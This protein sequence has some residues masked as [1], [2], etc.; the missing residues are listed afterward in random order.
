MYVIIFVALAMIGVAFFVGR[1]SKKEPNKF[2]R[3]LNAMGIR[4]RGKDLQEARALSEKTQNAIISILQI[5]SH[6]I[7]SSYAL[8]TEEDY[9][10][11]DSFMEMFSDGNSKRDLYH[12]AKKIATAV[13]ENYDKF[14]YC[15]RLILSVDKTFVLDNMISV[16]RACKNYSMEAFA[17]A[18]CDQKQ[19]GLKID[20]LS[21]LKFVSDGRDFAAFVNL[22]LMAKRAELD[23]DEAHLMNDIDD[24][25]LK[26]IIYSII[27]A[28][29][30]GIYLTDEESLNINKANVLEYSDSFKITMALLVDLYKLGRDVN[31]FTNVMIRAHNSGVMINIS[32]AEL[33]SMTDDEFDNL[34]TNIIRASDQGIS[35]DQKDLIRQNINGTDITNL[36]SALIKSNQCKLEFTPDD[37]MNYFVNTRSNVVNFVNAVDYSKKNKLG[38]SVDYLIEISKPE[39]NLF[40]FVQAVKIAKDLEAEE[41]NFGITVESVKEHFKKFNKAKEAVS[42]VIKARKELGLKMNFGIAGKIEEG[43]INPLDGEKYTM[44]S[45]IAWAQNPKVLEVEPCV[46]C[47]CKNGV[48]IT[49]KVNITV[50]GRMEQIFWGYKIDVL[51]KRINEAIIFEFESADNHE[52]ILNNLPK[53]SCNVLKRI[54]D[55]DNL[56]EIKT[57]DVSETD[58][59]KHC[60]YILLDVNIY[61]VKIGQ[62]VK[63]ELDL[64][65]A[66]IDS[67]MRRLKAEADRAKAE[68]DIRKAMVEQYNKGIRPNFNELHKADLLAED[69]PGII[70]GYE[71][72]E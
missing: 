64:R 21:A 13:P 7:E 33:H 62:N 23:I 34:I 59:N 3:S 60:S 61:D 51:F 4:L 29:Y 5:G 70:T 68:A 28:K 38:L 36:I 18:W 42:V 56:Q 25:G 49:P 2:V 9:S 27:R 30:E 10:I 35:I 1:T 14:M 67:E 40:D 20:F 19:A 44:K 72:P 63:A 6:V 11:G 53:I 47:V 65:Q 32:I 17:R 39:N 69:K 55:E 41:N 37:L 43:V 31:R 66:Q 48:Q 8:E 52:H 22:D 24:E 54:N 71:L 50:R 45:A 57:S 58:I 46:T 16:A 15:Y 26:T 12:I